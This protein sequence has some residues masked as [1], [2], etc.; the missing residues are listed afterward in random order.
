MH[1][2][3]KHILSKLI[4]QGTGYSTRAILVLAAI[5]VGVLLLSILIAGMIIDLRN[6]N[7]FTINLS[8]AALFI[9]SV[10][11]LWTGVGFAKAFGGRHRIE[12]HE[13]RECEHDEYVE[14]ENRIL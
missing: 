13:E 7:T 2:M 9:G 11:S 5:V 4:K 3:K 10:T 8:D 1:K 6:N 14:D 12:S